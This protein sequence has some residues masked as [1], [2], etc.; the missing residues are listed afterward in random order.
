MRKAMLLLVLLLMVPWVSASSYV[1]WVGLGDSITFGNYTLTIMDFDPSTR[2]VYLQLS[3]GEGTSYYSIPLGD[4][5]TVKNAS[6]KVERVFSGS[7]ARFYINAMFP[8]VMVGGEVKV[9]NLTLKVKSVEWDSFEVLAT[10]EG[11][12]KS[13]KESK[14]VIGN[15]SV[16]IGSKPLIF[17]GELKIGDNV[18]YGD[19]L[20]HIDGL[21]MTVVNNETSSVLVV[22]YNGS[23]YEI[24]EGEVA[25]IGVFLVKYNGFRCVMVNNLCDPRISLTVYLKALNIAISYNPAT[26]FTVYEGKDHAIGDFIVRVNGISDNYVYLS[27]L[28]SCGDV[29][30]SQ[31]LRANPVVIPSITYDGI[32]IGVANVSEDSN[33]EKATF[34]TF[35]NPE[36]RPRYLALLNVTL[37][38]INVTELV[39][40]EIQVRIKNIGNWKVYGMVAKF[41]PGDGIEVLGEDMKIIKE[42]DAGKEVTLK[43]KIVPLKAGNTTL[44]R[45]VIEGPVPY[46]LACGGLKALK[47]YSNEPKVYV[48]P[49]NVSVSV[50]S[51]K[52]VVVGSP[53]D[54]NFTIDA[55][56]GFAGILMLKLPPG[57]GVLS[58][59]EVRSGTYILQVSNGTHPVKLVA[60]T[61]GN[62]TVS[63]SLQAFGKEVYKSSLEIPVVKS[64]GGVQ[65]VTVT[66][67]LTIGNGTVITKTETVTKETTVTETKSEVKTTTKTSVRTQVL[68]RTV[69]QTVTVS[70]RSFVG[71]LLTFLIGAGV[72]AGLI[73]LIA[74]IQ[75]RR[76]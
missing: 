13:I 73:I 22:S 45:V 52:E 24:G 16:L 19:Y 9:E 57:V 30:Y 31:V 26:T 37:M 36:E 72:G 42:L 28:N 27:I 15:Y 74:W 39:P 51:P 70:E 49:L 5:L 29:L 7:V 62:Y 32:S 8:G 56:K 38:P 76:A 61:P 34:I 71:T 41:E 18:T 3:T 48:S 66:K 40:K 53:F 54:I 59:G 1:G 33:G 68:T 35:Y 14:A 64:N 58:E 60:V 12:E 6:I 65:V 46:P 4:T 11:E 67:T 21:N 20:L 55:P 75:A 17:N 47:F 2:S 63:L 23:K 69:T 10:Y 25:D 50:G 43:F 44:G